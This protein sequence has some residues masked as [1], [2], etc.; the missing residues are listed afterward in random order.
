MANIE[1][2][3]DFLNA[4]NVSF[5]FFDMGRRLSKIDTSTFLAFERNEIPYPFPLLRQ[6]WF[7]VLIWNPKQQNQQQI[8]FL[9]FPLDEQGKLIFAARNDLLKRLGSTLDTQLLQQDEE[10]DPLK[11]NP[12]SFT[13]DQ[14]KMAAFHAQ[15]TKLL[16]QQPSSFY[17]GVQ[18][19][20]MPS[21]DKAHWDKLGLQGIADYCARLDEDNQAALLAKALP[22]MPAEPI[23][24]FCQQLENTQLPYQLDDALVNLLEGVLSDD[25][26]PS[27][28]AVLVRGISRSSNA[29]IVHRFISDILQ[30]PNSNDIELLA[31][32]GSRCWVVLND[33][34]ICL[35]Y[36]QRL[37]E[38]NAGQASFALM[39]QDLLYLPDMREKIMKGLRNPE[40]GEAL[41]KAVGEFFSH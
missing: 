14:Q 11:D 13:P 15:A 25:P 19:Y 20:L 26:Q 24:A 2:L 27:Q 32:I 22:F 12:F 37:A 9:K 23:A 31:T 10:S 39:L 33:E 28:L 7:A 6:A 17:P 40:R 30:L 29:K 5:R 18:H 8:W 35:K 3:S 34:E 41:S 16:K 21:T 38:N 36:L 4:T 1:T